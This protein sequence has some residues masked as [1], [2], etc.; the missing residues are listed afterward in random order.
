M[1]TT[2]SPYGLV[3]V[4]NADGSPYCG[5]RDAF[6]IN[7]AGYAVQMGFGSVVILKDGYVQLSVK[8]GSANDAN[9]FAAVANGGALGVFVGCEYINA[10]GQLVFDQRYPAGT[11]APTGTDIIA[12]V[13]VDPGVTFQAQADGTV[14]QA[15]LGRNTFF[16]STP[17][18]D[19][20]S[21]TTGKSTLAV[22][23]TAVD[24]TAGFKIVGF[25][26]RGESEV[27]DTYTD[28]LVKF[29]GNFHAFAN[30]DVTS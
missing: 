11:V 13:V 5:A 19:D 20:V 12:Y 28:L 26:D 2:A 3:P 18:T 9:N 6:K 30:G 29:N 23:A 25:S 4:K 8:T 7:P 27:G 21:T 22:D 14:A 10:Q 15:F 17:D 24:T 1:A 16:P